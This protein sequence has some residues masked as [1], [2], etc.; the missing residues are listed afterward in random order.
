MDSYINANGGPSGAI[1]HISAALVHTQAFY[2]HTS[3][4]S[5]IQL[6]P[7]SK[8]FHVQG[9]GSIVAS[10]S[11]IT[12]LHDITSQI[13]RDTNAD[14]VTYLVDDPSGSFGVVGIAYVQS[15]CQQQ[16]GNFL[17]SS[18]NEYDTSVA[19]FGFVSEKFVCGSW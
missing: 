19:R 11:G 5:K 10:G 12:A 3:L 6:D 18:I 1:R 2:C 16:S 14:L 17:K 7:G 8:L 9:G 15:V 13:I 4:G